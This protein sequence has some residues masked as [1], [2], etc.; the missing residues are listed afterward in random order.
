MIFKRRLILRSAVGYIICPLVAARQFDTID[1]CALRVQALNNSTSTPKLGPFLNLE[2]C[3]EICGTGY[4]PYGMWSAFGSITSLVVPLFLLIG[5]IPYSGSL[6]NYFAVISS[7]I[8]NP[9]DFIWSLAA[10]LDAARRIA[11]RIDRLTISENV[12]TDLMAVCFAMDDDHFGRTVSPFLENFEQT[13]M[14]NSAI[15]KSLN[16]VGTD[17]RNNRIRN[18]RRAVL[19]I[20]VYVIS[21]ASTLLEAGITDQF[22]LFLSHTIAFRALFY[23][24]ILAV[25]LS[26]S[27]GA[28]SSPSTT[29]AFLMRLQTE[30]RD[31][32]Y[33]FAQPL[34]PCAWT[35]GSYAFR[36]HKRYSQDHR[37]LLLLSLSVFSVFS[38]AATAFLLS[39]FTPTYGMGDRSLAELSFVVFWVLNFVVSYA[40]CRGRQNRL[41]YIALSI[42]DLC[43][44]LGSLYVL[45]G[46][47]QGKSQSFFFS[48]LTNSGWYNNCKSW[49]AFWSRGP[50]NTIINLDSRDIELEKIRH[51]YPALVGAA[52]GV[53]IFIALFIFWLN[54]AALKRLMR[55]HELVEHEQELE[56]LNCQSAE[57]QGIAEEGGPA[58]P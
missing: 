30:L 29:H 3:L 1:Q 56:C 49:G 37:W 58:F 48:F 18:T 39:W 20:A 9:I 53:Q 36:P 42:K 2:Q 32:E 13:P 31:T 17:L 57:D 8:S 28:F 22:P 40:V 23:W 19:A 35:G 26:T 44:A 52:F 55:R 43:F 10:K 12:K 50:N 11:Y 41:A 51:F 21:V 4:G 27:I 15:R 24:I 45:L 46:A 34:R 38:A 54:R 6:V 33:A 16:S 25:A 47:F 14:L 5:N 7:L